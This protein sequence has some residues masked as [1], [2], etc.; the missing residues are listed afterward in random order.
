MNNVNLSI[1]GSITF[2]NIINELEFNDILNTG[3]QFS[4]IDKKILIRILFVD[5][6]KIKDVKTY[7]LK[8]EPTI[9]FLNN[10]N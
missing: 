2:S 10:K 3:S 8:N 5:S 4:H 7:L 6:F 9:L 1:S